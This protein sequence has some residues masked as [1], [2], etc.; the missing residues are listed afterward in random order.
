MIMATDARRGWVGG[1]WMRRVGKARREWIKDKSAVD[2]VSVG[3]DAAMLPICLC[4]LIDISRP[5]DVYKSRYSL[6]KHKIIEDI[7][8][9]YLLN[10]YVP[11][12]EIHHNL[13][14]LRS[15]NR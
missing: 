4:Q 3:V 2:G 5:G 12:G 11:F 1:D 14:R 9:T 7:W 10:K 8:T 15:S 6:E 13:H